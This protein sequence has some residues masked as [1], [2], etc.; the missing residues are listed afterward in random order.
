VADAVVV[1]SALV[2]RI[3]AL[4]DEPEKI[5]AALREVLAAMRH[6]MDKA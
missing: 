1:G 2:S 5:A 3:E 4:A 6:E